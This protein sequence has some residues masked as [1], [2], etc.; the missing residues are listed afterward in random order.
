MPYSDP[1]Q[2]REYMRQWIAARRAAYFSGKSCA[3]CGSTEKLELGHVDPTQKVD[4]KIWS[5]RVSRR[6][7][8]LAKCQV[9]CADCHTE[10]TVANEEH[11][12]GVRARHAKLTEAQVKEIRTRVSSG[13]TKRGLAREYGVDEK[14]IRAIINGET[15]KQLK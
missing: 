3:K 1:D 14:A 11:G 9:L 6:E 8:E 12:F 10:K 13:E 4:H 15:W 5:W 2:Q 7:A